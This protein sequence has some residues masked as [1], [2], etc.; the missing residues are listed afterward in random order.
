M[1]D[2]W[3]SIFKPAKTVGVKWTSGA[4]N[5]SLILLKIC[6]II[7]RKCVMLNEDATGAEAPHCCVLERE[8]D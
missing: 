7:S 5:D 1:A 4:P 6:L 2:R 8:A 3:T